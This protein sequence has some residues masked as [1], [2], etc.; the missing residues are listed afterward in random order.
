MKEAFHAS[1]ESAKEADDN[2]KDQKKHVA[3]VRQGKFS[4]YEH[5]RSDRPHRLSGEVLRP[6]LAKFPKRPQRERSPNEDTARKDNELIFHDEPSPLHAGT[7]EVVPASDELK[8]L[9]NEAVVSVA[10]DDNEKPDKLKQPAS[11]RQENEPDAVSDELVAWD[12]PGQAIAA[13]QEMVLALRPDVAEL[14]KMGFPELA[15]DKN[16]EEPEATIPE[17]P[18]AE[19]SDP[20]RHAK[21]SSPLEES[22]P[23]AFPQDQQPPVGEAT[24]NAEAPLPHVTTERTGWGDSDNNPWEKFAAGLA[25]PKYLERIDKIDARERLNDSYH[26]S[27]ETGLSAAVGLIGLG[28]VFE[29]FSAKRRDKRLK[30]QIEAQGRQ[31]RK[32]NQTVQLEQRASRLSHQKLEWL[33][34]S[35]SAKSYHAR[36]MVS[37]KQAAEVATAVAAAR[38]VE[39]GTSHLSTNHEWVLAERLMESK[40]LG[41]ALKQNPELKDMK[42]VSE[43]KR[44]LAATQETVA[45]LERQVAGLQREVRYEKLRGKHVDRRRGAKLGSGAD[46]YGMPILPSPQQQLPASV[47]A[48]LKLSKITLIAK[49]GTSPARAIVPVAAAT[50]LLILA[51]VLVIVFTKL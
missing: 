10:K 44:A 40:A 32:T 20:E 23:V 8:K 39:R 26:G 43:L 5:P 33:E 30:R 37:A 35:R 7:A 47:Q 21:V 28:L 6:L 38:A 17:V 12:K 46:G 9:H 25:N 48:D 51:A 41:R 22:G 11:E 1:T 27:R 50:V 18:A 42:D 13:F 15:L 36:T 31:L 19:L 29:H 14:A 2:K 24:G 34:A 45:Q 3:K 4:S 49:N 16:T